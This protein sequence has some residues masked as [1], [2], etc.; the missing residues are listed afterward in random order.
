VVQ[1]IYNMSDGG[2][3]KITTARYLTPLGRDIQHRGID[4]DILVQQSVDP[5]LI[6]TPKD[7]QLAA[8]EAYLHRVAR[9]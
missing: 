7:A 5:T 6:D 9:R 3:L 2:A 4:P 8:A 1:S